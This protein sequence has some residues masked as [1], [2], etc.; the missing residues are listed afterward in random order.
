MILQHF[1]E[2]YEYERDTLQAKFSGHFFE[3]SPPSLLDVSVE[4]SG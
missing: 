3:V 1:K 4:S 2:P